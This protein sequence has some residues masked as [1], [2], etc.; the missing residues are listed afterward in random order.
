M[1]AKL[2]FFIVFHLSLQGCRLSGT[3][4]MVTFILQGFKATKLSRSHIIIFSRRAIFQA[5]NRVA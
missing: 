4:I 1:K 5:V 3:T 2:N